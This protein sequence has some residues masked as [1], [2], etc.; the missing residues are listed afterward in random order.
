MCDADLNND[1]LVNSLDL[2]LFKP[3]FFTS[4]PD[5]DLNGDGIVNSLDLSLFK[6]LFFKPPGPSAL[7]P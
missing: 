2:S 3:V 5:A 1:G 6:S 4:N 7:T